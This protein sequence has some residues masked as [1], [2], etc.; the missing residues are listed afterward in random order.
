MKQK[1][2][3]TAILPEWINPGKT[4]V[5]VCIIASILFSF[6]GCQSFRTGSG[7]SLESKYSLKKRKSY[8]SCIPEGSGPV[9]TRR[10]PLRVSGRS[11][12]QL[13][14]CIEEYL[15]TRY[16]PGGTNPDGFDCSGFVQF[17]YKNNFRMLLPRT[18]GE[19]A[20]LGSMVLKTQLRPGDLVF[21]SR[22][23]SR[24]DHVGIFTGENTFVHAST[25]GVKFSNLFEQYYFT[26]YA[27]ASRLLTTE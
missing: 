8:I 21:F 23:G 15:G 17:L 1:A 24:I 12:E 18:S 19:L 6:S 9:I 14:A 26:H 25:N 11:M 5:I 10:L 16:R 4:A 22:D 7:Y 20:L 3:L 2:G 27:F 13:H